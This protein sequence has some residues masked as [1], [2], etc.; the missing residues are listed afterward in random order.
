MPE[1][2]GLWPAEYNQLRGSVLIWILAGVAA[3]LIVFLGIIGWGAVWDGVVEVF[4]L[5]GHSK[6]HRAYAWS[7]DTDDPKHPRRHVTV[8]HIPPAISPQTAVQAA[9]MQEIRSARSQAQA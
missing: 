9:I 3:C 6:T 8:L 2:F 7:H 5:K 1:E 4:D